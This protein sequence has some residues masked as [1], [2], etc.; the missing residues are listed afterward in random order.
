MACYIALDI[1]GSHITSGLA[2]FKN[3]NQ[4][5][6]YTYHQPID[7]NATVDQLLADISDCIISVSKQLSHSQ[8]L[9]GIAISMPGPVNYKRG[10]SRIEH[11]FKSLFALDLKTSLFN[12]LAKKDIHVNQITFLNDAQSFLLGVLHQYSNHSENVLGITLGTGIG[13]ASYSGGELFSGLFD[14][15][16]LYKSN[17]KE[18]IAEDYFSTEWFLNQA[19]EK[20]IGNGRA[21][22]GVKELA[23]K[24]E[25]DQEAQLIFDHFGKNLAEYLNS[26]I[27][28]KKVDRIVFGGKIF[29][30]FHLFEESFRD[31]FTDEVSVQIVDKT[32]EYSLLGAAVDQKQNGMRDGQIE[33]RKSVSPVLPIHK[34]RDP[35]GY[36]IYPTFPLGEGKIKTGYNSLMEFI[37]NQDSSQIVID[38]N[39]GTIWDEVI[40]GLNR[41]FTSVG[42][43][44]N[45][46]CIDAAL[47]SENE[48]D[49]MLEGCL[50]DD[51]PLFGFNFPGRLKDFFDEK[52]LAQISSDKNTLSILYGTGSAL[53]GWEGPVI[54]ID[55]P[56]NEIQYRSRAGSVANIGSSKAE[57]A[58]K[59]YKR[60]YFVDW[61]VCNKHKQELL[62]KMAAVA[63]GQRPE[64]ITWTEGN[65]FRTGLEN[66]VKSPFRVR[67]WFEPGVWGGHW[68]KD[69]FE[70]LNPD[71]KNYAWSF[72]IIAPENGVIFESEGVMLEAGFEFLLYQNNQAVLG[73]H[74][75]EYGYYF[76]LRFDYLDTMDGQN[77]SLQ[78][79]PT[80]EYIRENF[81]EP[82]TQ[83]ETYYIMDAEPDADVYLGFQENIN[84]DQFQ[85]EFRQCEISGEKAD[86]ENY[87]Q[88][89]PSQKHDLFLIP[90]GTIHCSG[91]NNLV[92]EI[93]NTPYIFTFKIY[94][95]QRLDLD[96]NPRPLNVSRAMENLNF[97]R[98]GK[99]VEKELISKPEIHEEGEDWKIV[100][101]PTHKEHLYSI[102]RLEFEKSIRVN[103]VNKFH[104]LN[105]VEGKSVNIISNNQK[106]KLHYAE[107]IVIPAATG[108]YV[109]ENCTTGSAKVM[110]A[111]MK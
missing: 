46:Y 39:V 71:A 10:V 26:L 21:I 80:L 77:L 62:P 14:E 47:K 11:K 99:S 60:F 18:G 57:D 85:N 68:M 27:N 13:S 55:Q 65:D 54:Y 108:E 64:T 17:Y 107:T 1:G 69:R 36:D 31:L 59:M 109:M 63:D 106:I 6:E 38:G 22:A 61:P 95:W 32:S 43:G 41:E 2:N 101:L 19:A 97:G 53:T 35:D 29:H 92:L 105:L 15:N 30:S 3:S 82:I 88:T 94:D 76:P 49:S 23:D 5:V 103:T 67:P 20:G 75:E 58:K 86:V 66:I 83:D 42:T 78:C 81:G 50:G 56:K 4:K 74:A 72:E 28:H 52:L 100:N 9:K 79:H 45:W 51:D 25:E 84:P 91:K 16:P 73:R 98:N 7:N 70:G 34:K 37:R 102:H 90:A 8:N 33:I 93:S 89:F 48:I 87:V 44:V 40:S 110:K 96:G 104:V 111:F 12:I 24:A